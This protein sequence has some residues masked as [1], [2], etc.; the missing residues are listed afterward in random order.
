[1][2]N[3][4]AL[5]KGTPVVASVLSDSIDLGHGGYRPNIP[6]VLKIDLPAM[7]TTKVITI[8]I[9]ESDDNITFLETWKRDIAFGTL[10]AQSHALGLVNSKRHIRVKITAGNDLSA[11]KYSAYLFPLY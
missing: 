9:E 8:A 1:M 4:K 2:A 7:T 11:Q 5:P 10:S 3:D 6:Y